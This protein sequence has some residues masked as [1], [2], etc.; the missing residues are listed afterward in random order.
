MNKFSAHFWK[1]GDQQWK[2]EEEYSP[3]LGE[4]GSGKPQTKCCPSPAGLILVILVHVYDSFLK[5]RI[6][7]E[8]GGKN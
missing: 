2:G 4:E 6:V 8:E 3:S 7:E 5:L 1:L